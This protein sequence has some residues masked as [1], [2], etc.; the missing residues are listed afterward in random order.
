[1]SRTVAYMPCGCLAGQT[2][3]R[4]FIPVRDMLLPVVDVILAK[5]RGQRE[6]GRG[7]G[8]G[9][10]VFGAMKDVIDIHELPNLARL[11]PSLRPGSVQFYLQAHGPGQGTTHSYTSLDLQYYHVSG[12][13]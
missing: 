8:G 1:M 12:V 5:D 3:P 6:A 2:P 9:D 13:R 7:G 4:Y 10:F 11:F